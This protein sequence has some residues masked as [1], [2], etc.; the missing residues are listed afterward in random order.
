MLTGMMC[1]SASSMVSWIGM[2]LIAVKASCVAIKV[3]G[4]RGPGGPAS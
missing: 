1:S 2:V 4:H 3:W